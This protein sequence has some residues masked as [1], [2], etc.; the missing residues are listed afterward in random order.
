MLR[1]PN[2]VNDYELAAQLL[3]T[4]RTNGVQGSN[5][6]FLICAVAINHKLSVFSLDKDFE[7]YQKWVD[8]ALYKS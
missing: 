4:C 2:A 1:R 6:D 7:S 3:N 5:A 8:V